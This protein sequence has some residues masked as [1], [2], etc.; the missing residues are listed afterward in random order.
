[1]FQEYDVVSLKKEISSENITLGARGTILTVYDEPNLPRAYEV[2]F[3]DEKGFTI[4]LVTITE[5]YIEACQ[6]K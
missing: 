6:N 5:D 1:M 3:I 2:E 4:A